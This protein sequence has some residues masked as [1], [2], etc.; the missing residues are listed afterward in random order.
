[1]K[2]TRARWPHD[3]KDL[4]GGPKDFVRDLDYD[5]TLKPELRSVE[6]IHRDT[7]RVFLLD[8]T[9][10]SMEPAKAPVVPVAPEA[11]GT[12]RTVKSRGR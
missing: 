3:Q 2:L 6:A 7:G 12:A 5:L 8:Q 4:P 1:M 11:S 10:A 9:G